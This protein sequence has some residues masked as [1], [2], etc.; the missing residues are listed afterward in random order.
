[1]SVL[2]V[3]KVDIDALVTIAL[4]WSNSVDSLRLSQ[5]VHQAMHVSRSTADVVGTRLF[6]ANWNAFHYGGDP[7]LLDD[8]GR[9][10]FELHGIE[11]FPGYNFSE[12][13]GAPLPETCLHLVG[14]Y[15]HQTAGDNWLGTFPERFVA[16]LTECAQLQ[17]G[18]LRAEDLPGY[19]NVPWGLDEHDRN[20][21]ERLSI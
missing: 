7:D 17:L 1:M 20:L 5:A 3:S 8:E 13:P 2:L 4:R 19:A 12:L 18:D 10:Y 16:A 9:G 6:Q 14:F 21:F 11:P 15:E